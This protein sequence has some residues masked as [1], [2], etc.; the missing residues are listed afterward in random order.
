MASAGAGAPPIHFHAHRTRAG[1]GGA[2]EDFEQML[3]LLVAAV[4]GPAHLVFASHHG[5]WG[6]DVLVGE[7]SGRVSVWQAKYFVDGVKEHHRQAI[8]R[9]FDRAVSQAREKGYQIGRWVLCVPTSLDG[10]TRQWW[11]DWQ[12]KHERP[13]LRIELWDENQLR[14]LLLKREAAHV[15][16]A[17]YHPYREDGEP[18]PAARP[19]APP[20]PPD[21]RWCGGN[22]VPIGGASYLL[23]DD[24]VEQAVADHAWL[25]REA[26]ADRLESASPDRV[27]LR[28]VEA[29]RRTPAAAQAREALRTQ[30]RLLRDRHPRDRHPRDRHPRDG[31]PQDGLPRDGLPELAGLHDGPDGATTTLVTGR[32]PGRTWREAFGPA[33]APGGTGPVPPDRLTAAAALAAAAEVGDAL[34]RL[35]RRGHAHRALG[36]DGILFGDRPRRTVLRDLGL[37]GMPP[38]AGEGPATY[39]APEQARVPAGGRPG[40]PAV[41]TYQLA[42]VIYHTVTGHPPSPAATP[43]VRASLAGFPEA[44]DGLIRQALDPDPGRRPALPALVAALRAG[45]RHLSQGG[46]Q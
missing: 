30:A 38:R 21:R 23:H 26:T 22:Q 2:P 45:R 4:E 6:I 16:I 41:D 17:Y 37:V 1:T 20:S 32:P 40:G 34:G 13:D 14:S 10:P 29:L 27:W 19:A 5:D 31:L 3:A 15:R 25:W 11:R 12:A 7:L 18:E 8:S 43:P 33:P 36:P 24:A 28:Q 44:L 35:H 9:S 42:A 46:V 39:R